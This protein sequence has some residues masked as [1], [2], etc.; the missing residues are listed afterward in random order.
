MEPCA[1]LP[2]VLVLSLRQL[3][4]HMR[5]VHRMLDDLKVV[6]DTEGLRINGLAK[7]VGLGVLVP[8]GIKGWPQGTLQLLSSED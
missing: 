1:Y 3:L 4:V 7:W 2:R 5:E 8:Y 6:R